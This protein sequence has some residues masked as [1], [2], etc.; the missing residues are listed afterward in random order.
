MPVQP[1]TPCP[2][3]FWPYMCRYISPPSFKYMPHVAYMSQAYMWNVCVNMCHKYV[4]SIDH[5]ISSTAHILWKVHFMLLAYPTQ[6]ICLPHFKYSPHCPH[7]L[8]IYIQHWC[9]YMQI[10]SQPTTSSSHVIVIYVS[11]TNMPTILHIYI[12]YLTGIYGGCI[13]HIRV[14]FDR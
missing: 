3:H 6:E 5:V 1:T 10:C 11:I 8:Y 4:T 7:S 14:L 12:T 9:I 13:W 2:P